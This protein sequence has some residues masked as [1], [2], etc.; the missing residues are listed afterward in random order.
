MMDLVKIRRD[1]HQIPE[2]GFKE[3]QTSQ[4][5]E[6][7]LKTFSCQIYHCH[8]G[9]IAYF[10][11][12]QDSTLAYRCE[13]DGLP[14]QEENSISYR[15]KNQNMH[16]C[17]HDGH[18]AIALGICQYLNQTN[19]QFP[20]NFAIIFQPSEESYGG[21][22]E[23]IKS[24]YLEKLNVKKILSLHFFPK[25][26]KRQFFTKDVPFSSSREINIILRG[27]S[28][29]VGNKKQGIDALL[30][31]SKLV[32]NLD[33]FN[34]SNT[35]VHFGSFSSQG[36][37]NVVSPQV[38]LK[39]T[40]REIKTT[41]ILNKIKKII[42]KYQKKYHIDINLEASKYL[43]SLVNNIELINKGK[44]FIDIHQLTKTYF[45]SEDFSL[46]TNKYPCLYLL[47]GLGDSDYLHSSK[48]NFDDQILNHCLSQ[49]IKL[50]KI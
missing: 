8:T 11:F 27:K 40:I 20:H 38:E 33:K 32:V 28:V 47:Y 43:P 6:K 45:Q 37:R 35:I 3:Y 24:S 21:S 39:G 46:Y 23:I 30:I 22:L 48:F 29:H 1:L 25:L 44:K 49:V 4:Y 9:L 12:H 13:L 26:T 7:I 50:L 2:V 17:A 16:A 41:N 31:A 10:D 42:D 36:A 15:S 14:I 19:E 34:T 18:M 5:I